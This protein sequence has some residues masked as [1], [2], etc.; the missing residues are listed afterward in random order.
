[1]GEQEPNADV[2]YNEGGGLAERVHDPSVTIAFRGDLYRWMEDLARH[3]RDATQP[4]DVARI[5]IELLYL[6]RGKEVVLRDSNSEKT[7]DLWKRT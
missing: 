6:A 2:T 3:L 4:A 5:G 7:V 1:M